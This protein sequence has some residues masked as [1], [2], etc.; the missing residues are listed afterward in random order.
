M[1]LLIKINQSINRS[2]NYFI[3]K[4]ANK[5][6]K[7]LEPTLEYIHLICLRLYLSTVLASTDSEIIFVDGS[8]WL[9]I[10]QYI[11]FLQ[12]LLVTSSIAEENCTEPASLG[13]MDAFLY[14][15]I[16]RQQSYSLMPMDGFFTRVTEQFLL[17]SSVSRMN[18]CLVIAHV[19]ATGDIETVAMAT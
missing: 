19:R 11:L 7:A 9:S 8:D 12:Y 2:I 4:H 18:I 14:T 3:I 17:I 5:N 6:H 10:R 1:L 16:I 13:H 15:D